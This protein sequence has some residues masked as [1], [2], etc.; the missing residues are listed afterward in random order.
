MFIFVFILFYSY[1]LNILFVFSIDC[2]TTNIFADIF[3]DIVTYL[4]EKTAIT[5]FFLCLNHLQDDF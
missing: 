4:I 5:L 2:G 3:I 1:E